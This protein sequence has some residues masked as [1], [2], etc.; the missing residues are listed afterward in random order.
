MHSST[1]PTIH[2]PVSSHVTIATEFFES[3]F[4]F[5]V[6]GAARALGNVGGAKFFD[7]VAHAHRF[8][9]NWGGARPATDGAIALAFAIGEIERNHGNAFALDIFPDVQLGPVQ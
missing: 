8:G 3:V 4:A 5:F 6:L 7:D 9:F 2:S 1:H